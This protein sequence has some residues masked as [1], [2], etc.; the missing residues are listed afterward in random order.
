MRWYEVLL[1][2]RVTG[3]T[4][5][6]THR[7]VVAASQ[8]AATLSC[9]GR[10]WERRSERKENRT[11]GVENET[12]DHYLKR[13]ATTTQRETRTREQCKSLSLTQPVAL[14]FEM[15]PIQIDQKKKESITL[16]S[17]IM[18]SPS[19]LPLALSTLQSLIFPSTPT[20]APT[21]PHFPMHT[22]VT[23]HSPCGSGTSLTTLQAREPR[24]QRRRARV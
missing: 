24:G 6:M 15:L 5:L 21:L 12:G 1:S 16:S 19:S 14:R 22:P 7:S 20:D 9:G 10:R 23:P 18:S 2:E 17:T 13:E 4:R 3:E 8:A 11:R